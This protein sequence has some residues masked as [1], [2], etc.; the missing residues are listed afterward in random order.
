MTNSSPRVKRRTDT[1]YLHSVSSKLPKVDF[2][3]N[4]EEF[5]EEEF[6]IYDPFYR[7]ELP[8]PKPSLSISKHS[9]AKVP[10]N[11]N[12]RLELQLLLTSGT[13]LPNSRP[14]LSERVRKHTHLLSNSITGDDKPSLIHVDFTPEECFIL[15]EAKLKF[16]PVNSVQFNDAY[17]THISPKLPGRAYE[18]CQK[19]EI[20]NPS[21]SPVDKHGAIILRTYKKNKKL[22]PDY[23]KSFYNAGSSYFQ[24]EQ[25]HQL[26]DGE[27]VFFLK[28]WKHF[29][30]TSGDTVCVA[31]NPLCEKF[32]LGST[33]Q[34][35]AYN[36][37]GNLWIGD[38]QSETIQSLESH[39]KLNQIGEKEYSTISDLCF[40]KGNLF[41]YTGAFDNAV[42]VW[43]MEGNLC[44]IFNAPTDYIH[45]LAL[46]DD[47]LLAVAC[48]NGY[49]YLLSTDNSTGEI[50][51]SANLIYP[52]AL[53][54]G[55]S[56][57]L[58]EFSN[59]LGRSSDKVIIGYDSFHT[60]NN[61][62][63]LALF[64]AS[65]ASFVQKFN[66]ADE[67]FTSLYMHPSQVG[68]VA[69]SNT[70]SNGRVYYLDTRMYKVCL[71]FTTTQKDIN[72]ATISN[73]GILVTSS[74][75]DNQTFVW[76][77]RKP[78]KPLSLLKHG[79]TKMIHFDG[80]NEEEVDAGINMAQWQPKGNL[81]VTGGSDG[82][83]KVW[84][85]RLNNPFIQNFTEMNSAITYGGFSED[86]SKLTVCCVGGDV[87]MY[88]LGN[89]NG[90]KFGEFRIIENRLLT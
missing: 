38:F 36:R 71:N 7:A 51:T 22:L 9:I 68:F 45:K 64:D 4:N 20:D 78:D 27:S 90:N 32:A 5:F 60:S 43:D 1:Q 67:A 59:F 75:T 31:Y 23:L 79:K 58:I 35:G 24:R 42:K 33:A 50:L 46:S 62:G 86:A 44:G 26:M 77:S 55:Y 2:D 89:D 34:D 80:A 48:K 17:S 14:Y 49:G 54:K 61:R 30:E 85:L 6:E 81:F 18:D 72:H 87:N 39:Y 25:V 52:E 12:K 56:A 82:I 15:Q 29:N 74:G 84:D 88:N 37:L 21:L 41:L 19:F 69:S 70:L 83:V 16:G 11:V 73:S 53:E 47:D 63:C 40:S 57:S 13:F 3:T 76:D 8:C 65:T 28:P 10:S 66:T